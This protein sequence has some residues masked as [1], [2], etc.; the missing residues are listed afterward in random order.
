MTKH[1]SH[2]GA[3]ARPADV[4]TRRTATAA[5]LAIAFTGC[6]FA[7]VNTDVDPTAIVEIRVHGDGFVEF[8]G[9]RIPLEAAVLTM[10][11]RFRPMA[12]SER[13]GIV[14]QLDRAPVADTPA[15]HAAIAAD[16]NRL[17]EQCQIM[18]VQHARVL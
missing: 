16:F 11:Q 18:G 14:V 6:S 1:P 9:E 5:L 4:V 2:P 12:V 10:R 8:E 13:A 3:F 15:V 17:L 7:P